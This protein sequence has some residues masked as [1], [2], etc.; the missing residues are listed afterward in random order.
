MAD[1]LGPGQRDPVRNRVGHPTPLTFEIAVPIGA[2]GTGEIIAVALPAKG[3][4][5]PTKD[6]ML[7]RTPVDAP[8]GSRRR[9]TGMGLRIPDGTA[10]IEARWERDEEVI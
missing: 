5:W 7:L 4:G 8:S 10:A 3:V 6:K 9:I 1:E 2:K